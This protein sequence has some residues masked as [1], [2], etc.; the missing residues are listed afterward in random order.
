MRILHKISEFSAPTE[1][2]VTIYVSYIR[3]I[4]EQS[5]TIWHLS[6]TIKDSADL[7]RVQKS[8]MEIML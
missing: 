3:S 5:C 1:D 7:E 8:D 2:M 6:L 4:L